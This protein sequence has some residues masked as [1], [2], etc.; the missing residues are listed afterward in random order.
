MF[1]LISNCKNK[2]ISLTNTN[3]GSQT[4]FGVWLCVALKLFTSRTEPRNR[5]TVTVE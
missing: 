4:I 3:Y 2:K 1:A 5:A